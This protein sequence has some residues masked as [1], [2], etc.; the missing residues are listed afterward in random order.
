MDFHYLI[1]VNAT[2]LKLYLLCIL[3]GVRITR[4]FIGKLIS[5]LLLFISCIYLFF[6]IWRSFVMGSVCVH[7][8]KFWLNL[9]TTADLYELT[10]CDVVLVRLYLFLDLT[11]RLKFLNNRSLLR[12]CIT[13]INWLFQLI[14]N[15]DLRNGL[16]NLVSVDLLVG[17]LRLW[18]TRWIL[19]KHYR[20][21]ICYLSL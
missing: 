1:R 17:L 4:F 8:F 10:M 13:I 20:F 14:L 18:F 11:R 16:F 6:C 12:L 2:L 19:F 9:V 7:N 3:F 5:F 21:Q 15:F